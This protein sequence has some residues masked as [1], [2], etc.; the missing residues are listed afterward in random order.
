MGLGSGRL[1]SD[2]SRAS[3]RAVMAVVAISRN[4][5]GEDAGARGGIAGGGEGGGGLG[6]GASGG[7]LE[8][9]VAAQKGT[10]APRGGMGAPAVGAGTAR[11]AAGVP[12]AAGTGDARAG[13]TEA[14]VARAAVMVAWAART[15]TGAPRGEAQKAWRSSVGSRWRCTANYCLQ[16]PC[17][18]RRR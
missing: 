14:L 18:P 13:T 17:M 16:C 1:I 5:E 3:P 8:E 9:A 15:A 4:R 2:Q 7:K 12:M 10:G 11:A 6:L